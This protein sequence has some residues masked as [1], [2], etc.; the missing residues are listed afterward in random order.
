MALEPGC[1]RYGICAASSA[2]ATCAGPRPRDSRT[3]GSSSARAT[4]CTTVTPAATAAA[5]PTAAAAV[6]VRLAAQ[7]A[8]RSNLR[9]S[10]AMSV[11]AESL[12]RHVHDVL[13]RGHQAVADFGEG[14]ERDAG[15][16]SS[17]PLPAADPRPECRARR[18]RP[19]RWLLLG[20]RSP[21]SM[22][23]CSRMSA[24]SLM[25]PAFERPGQPGDA[26]SAPA[27][28]AS[29]SAPAPVNLHLTHGAP[30]LHVRQV[31]G[32]VDAGLAQPCQL[33]AQGARADAE[34]LG[35]VAGG[36]VAGAQRIE[37][38]CRAR[39]DRARRPA[40]RAAAAVGVRSGFGCACSEV[41]LREFELD[42]LWPDHR[43]V[44]AG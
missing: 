21:D 18:H 34:R 15:P 24:K 12:Q 20:R 7:G 6:A 23:S 8:R 25:P 38:Q 44:A 31:S 42:V 43:P 40:K 30:V 11:P 41:S 16:L 5:M 14:T 27:P 4:T 26:R 19:V 28:T 35:G 10:A 22:P 2:C 36:S 33:V 1:E 9:V 17:R 37:D 32:H 13:V 39:A 3:A 29:G